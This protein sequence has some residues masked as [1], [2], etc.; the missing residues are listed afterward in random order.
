MAEQTTNATYENMAMPAD[1]RGDHILNL[2]TIFGNGSRFAF[3][4]PKCVLVNQAEPT[5]GYFTFAADCHMIGGKT[6]ASLINIPLDAGAKIAFAI[7]G[8]GVMDYRNG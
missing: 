8:A 2:A 4:A 6:I 3:A 7:D 5:L 1:L